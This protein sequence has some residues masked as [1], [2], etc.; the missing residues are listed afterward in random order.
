LGVWVKL[1]VA[2]LFMT[3]L[4]SIYAGAYGGAQAAAMW[5]Q[6]YGGTW[7]DEAYSLVETPDGGYLMAGTTNSF[8]SDG[9]DIWLV[10]TDMYGKME[11]NKTYGGTEEEGA[12]S[13]VEASDGGY[14][15][16][17]YTNSSGAGSYDFWLLKIDAAGNMEWNVTYGGAG[18]D[19]VSSMVATSDGG[20]ALAGRTDSFGS[21]GNDGWLVKTDAFGNMEWNTTYGGADIDSVQ[22]LVASL[23]GGYALSGYTVFGFFSVPDNWLIKV[24]EFGNIEWNQTYTDWMNWVSSLAVTSDGGYALAGETS[25]SDNYD[26]FLVKTDAIGNMEWNQTYDGADL[27]IAH[28]LVETSDGGYGLAGATGSSG[29]GYQ[30]FWLIKTDEYGVVSE[31]AWVI[32]LLLLIAT[33]S[34]F[35]CRNRLRMHHS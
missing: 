21:G 3:L 23:D 32:L 19:L 29:P 17:G 5:S 10:K 4:F 15:I 34:I 7:Y 26:V 9:Y 1:L 30:D 8:G 28:S 14:A 18:E 13:L 31:D 33:V 22:S 24:D 6:T 25:V 20:Y 2:V 35:I 27:D 16:A 11:W 12:H